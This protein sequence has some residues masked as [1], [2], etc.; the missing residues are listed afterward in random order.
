VSFS[1]DSLFD[2][3]K[4]TVKPAGKQALDQFAPELTGL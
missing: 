4:E 2:F 1:A 3:G